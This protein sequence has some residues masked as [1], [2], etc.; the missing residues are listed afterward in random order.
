M[1]TESWNLKG[2]YF[3]NCNCEVLCPCV[4][5]GPP[6]DPTEGHCD[7][8]FAF[9]VQEGDFGGVSLD[10]LNFVVIAY[11]PGNMG[12]GNWTT[13]V[14][15]DEKANDAQRKALDRILSGEIGG[16][17]RI[18]MPL[19]TDFKGT[20]YCPIT[21]T[22]EGRNRGVS[23]PEIMDFNV[24]GIVADRGNEPMRLENAPHEVNS[25]LTLARSTGSTYTDHGM[26]WDNTSKNG[27]YAPFNW[28]WP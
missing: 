19:T 14:Y 17:A 5:P 25:T 9:H 26:S 23:I 2:E 1:T 22:S 13:A 8:G 4:V 18:W 27:L 3:E 15:I 20:K 6:T 21:Y 16:P 28:Q 7:V 10:D 12:A 24:E 11:T